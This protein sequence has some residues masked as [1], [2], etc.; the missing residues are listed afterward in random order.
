MGF[1]SLPQAGGCSLVVVHGLLIGVASLVEHG[2]WGAWA[3]VI[4]AHG[5]SCPSASSQ[6]RD[7]TRVP[8][9]GR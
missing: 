5:L 2:L 8:C 3:S 6:M 9:I 7:Q 1:L 4:V